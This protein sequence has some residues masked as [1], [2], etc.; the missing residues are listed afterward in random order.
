MLR[1]E[2]RRA[3]P[4]DLVLEVDAVVYPSRPT[5][6][7]LPEF[8]GTATI[9]QTPEQRARLCEFVV[10]EYRD[11]RRSLR[12]IAEMTGRTQTAIRRVLDDQGVP[13]RGR[14]APLLRAD[15]DE[16]DSGR[17]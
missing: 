10:N 9:K 14:G 11:E 5:R 8:V 7:V 4:D 3:P 16:R 2:P 15:S 6:A 17:L 12:E 13:R 1:S